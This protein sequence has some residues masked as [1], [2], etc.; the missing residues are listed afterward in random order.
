MGVSK[1]FKEKIEKLSDEDK[2]R[3]VRMGWEDRS[4]YDAIEVQFELTPNEFIKFMRSELDKKTFDRWRK[5]A[6]ERGHLK[7]AE[8]RGV[9]IDR[10]KCS[11]QSVDGITKGWK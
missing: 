1:S 7:H 3:L 9:E 6:G 11:R 8:T 5:R 4:T 10:F 2:D